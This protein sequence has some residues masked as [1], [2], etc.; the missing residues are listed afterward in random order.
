MT[1]VGDSGLRYLE[2]LKHLEVVNL[3]E[4]LVTDDGVKRLQQAL[5]NCKIIHGSDE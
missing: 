1:N 2:T 5:P 4:T 3:T